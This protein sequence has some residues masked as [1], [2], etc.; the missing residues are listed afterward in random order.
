MYQSAGAVSRTPTRSA[1]QASHY[2]HSQT[3]QSPAD[4]S[5]RCGTVATL[6][7][8]LESLFIKSSSM[9]SCTWRSA[10]RT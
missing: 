1:P 6:G 5:W 4:L 3:F 10:L 8:P 7:Q 9:I 2:K